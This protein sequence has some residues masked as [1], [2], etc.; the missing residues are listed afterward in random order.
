MHSGFVSAFLPGDDKKKQS[1]KTHMYP[2]TVY[3]EVSREKC[4]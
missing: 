4:G 3:L 2:H 1:K